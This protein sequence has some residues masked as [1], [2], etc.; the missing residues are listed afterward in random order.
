MPLCEIK[1]VRKLR[2]AACLAQYREGQ[3]LEL[4]RQREGA[5]PSPR[6]KNSSTPERILACRFPLCRE[7]RA[8]PSEARAFCC[9]G[10]RRS[11][12]HVRHD[13]LR[14]TRPAEGTNGVRATLWEHLVQQRIRS[15][16]PTCLPSRFSPPRPQRL[17]RLPKPQLRLPRLRRTRAPRPPQ[18]QRRP[19]RRAD[20]GAPPNW[21]AS[22]S[23]TSRTRSSGTSAR[24]SSTRPS[25]LRPTPRLGLP[26]T[27]MTLA[28]SERETWARYRARLERSSRTKKFQSAPRRSSALSYV[29][30]KR[31]PPPFRPCG[32]HVPSACEGGHAAALHSQDRCPPARGEQPPW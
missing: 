10:T 19:R 30:N 4:G 15:C 5:S 26:F 3:R 25:F 32:Q 31:S 24:Y 14:H 28:R 6:S 29:R 27:S 18:A 7:G 22:M 1:T 23:T 2:T 8:L 11:K 21:S 16:A 20:N 13:A 9:A 17:W 12:A